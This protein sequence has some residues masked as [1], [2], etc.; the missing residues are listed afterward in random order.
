MDIKGELKEFSK[1]DDQEDVMKWGL[2]I[3]KENKLEELHDALVD[4]DLEEAT[5]RFL[6]AMMILLNWNTS[7]LEVGILCSVNKD[8]STRWIRNNFAVRTYPI[9]KSRGASEQLLSTFGKD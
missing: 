5:T 9:M 1:E 6:V 3:A 2:E 8:T 7:D 4:L